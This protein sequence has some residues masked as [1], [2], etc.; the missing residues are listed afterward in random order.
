MRT[1]GNCGAPVGD[2][3]LFCTECGAK[4]GTPKK[5]CPHCGATI[6]DDSLFCAECGTKLD[7]APVENT[8]AQTSV[9]D[10]SP[11]QT[12]VG[13]TQTQS[14][15]DGVVIEVKKKNNSW[16]YVIACIL[17]V[18]LLALAG[19]YLLNK[20][21]KGED[22]KIEQ[23]ERTYYF[24]SGSVGKYPI[25]MQLTFEG[26]VVEG[27]YYYDKQGPDKVLKLE[28]VYNNDNHLFLYEYDENGDKSGSFNGTFVNGIFDGEFVTAEGKS[29]NFHVSEKY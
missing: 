24:L 1:C 27:H 21:D 16:I 15:S 19:Y 4:V 20:K 23:I 17:V 5:Q 18:S 7:V 6:D 29:F 12:V 13:Y 14:G 8:P 2:G 22:L 25:T 28:G 9:E 3:A 10:Q 11:Q 26:S